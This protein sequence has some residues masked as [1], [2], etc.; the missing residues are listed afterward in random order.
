VKLENTAGLA[1][2]Q[3]DIGRKG[4]EKRRKTLRIKHIRI[5]ISY[6]VPAA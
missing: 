3:T 5:I 4:I 2:H 1:L 6:Q